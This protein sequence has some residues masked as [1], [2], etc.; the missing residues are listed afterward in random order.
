MQMK[1]CSIK[2]EHLFLNNR[3]HHIIIY[4]SIVKTFFKIVIRINQ[5]P[6]LTTDSPESSFFT[7]KFCQIRIL[8][9]CQEFKALQFL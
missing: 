7:G 1:I 4:L 9:I 2:Y 8:R 5:I 6:Y 3:I